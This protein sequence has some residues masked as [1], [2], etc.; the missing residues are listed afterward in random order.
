[1]KNFNAILLVLVF[2]LLACSSS[3]KNEATS[4]KAEEVKKEAGSTVQSEKKEI[5]KDSGKTCNLGKDKRA[6]R[7]VDQG[8]GC[9]VIY[10]KFGS[11]NEIASGTNG[12]SHC[13]NV[14]DRIIN[15]LK[16]AGF[17]CS[18]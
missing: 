17:S 11:E 10:S 3:S 1:M 18:E 7:I 14:Q 9:K 8:K 12:L 15:N 5:S 16:A 4:S 6:I 13:Q 2:S